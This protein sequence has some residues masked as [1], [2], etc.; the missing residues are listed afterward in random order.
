MKYVCK[1]CGS[2]NVCQ[3][4]WLNVNTNEIKSQ[5]GDTP[6]CF[7]CKDETDLVKEDDYNDDEE[8]IISTE[9]GFVIDHIIPK[10]Q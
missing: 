3:E 7:D 5:S 2:D 1:Y 4:Y 9:N 10:L 6:Y 8:I